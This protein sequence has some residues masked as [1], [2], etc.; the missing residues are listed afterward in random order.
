[1]YVKVVCIGVVLRFYTYTLAPTFTNNV[2]TCAGLS[3]TTL[4]VIAV[5]VDLQEIVSGNYRTVLDGASLMKQDLLT[6]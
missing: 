4:Q 5:S 1:M 2:N 6:T 3:L